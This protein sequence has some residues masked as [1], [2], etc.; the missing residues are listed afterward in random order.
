MRYS[1]VRPSSLRASGLFV[2]SS[3]N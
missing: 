3:W 2:K 1:P